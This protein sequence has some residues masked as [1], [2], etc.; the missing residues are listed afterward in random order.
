MYEQQHDR[1]HDVIV[2]LKKT[3]PKVKLVC[4]KQRDTV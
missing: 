4:E 1:L 3:K 2:Y